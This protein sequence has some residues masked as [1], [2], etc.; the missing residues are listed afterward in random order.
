MREAGGNF[1]EGLSGSRSVGAKQTAGRH[2][3]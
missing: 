3:Q 2:F 1:T